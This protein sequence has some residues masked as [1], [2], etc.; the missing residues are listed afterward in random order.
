MAPPSKPPII[1]RPKLLPPAGAAGV[2]GVLAGALLGL[3]LKDLP[4]AF[5]RASASL[6]KNAPSTKDRA[7]ST[8]N[9]GANRFHILFMIF[10]LLCCFF[11]HHRV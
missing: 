7:K 5:E 2:A 11:V 1:P 4:P 3:E 9:T 10:Q 6:V 8:I